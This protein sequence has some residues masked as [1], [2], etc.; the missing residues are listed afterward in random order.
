M[1][2]FREALFYYM[3][4]FD[5]FDA[6]IPRECKS[7]LMLEQVVLGRSALN[8]IACE[9]M[10]LVQRPEKYKQW[11]ARN[12]RA[13]LRQLPLKSSIVDV[14]KDEVK[15]HHHKDF[16]VCE[17][18]KWLLQ[19]WMGRVLFAHSTWGLIE[20]SPPSP[21]LF[22]DLPQKPNG[23]SEGQHH[24]PNNDMMLPY[25]SCLL[26]EDDVDDK[27]IDHPALLQ[28]QQPFAQILSTPSFSTSTVN[29]EGFNDLL[30]QG[31]SDENTLNLA[32]SKDTDAVQA[33]M[34]GMEEANMLVPKDNFRS[35]ELVNQMV[36]ESINHCGVKKRY[37][38]DHHL[39]EGIRRTRKTVMMIKGPEANL[40]NE[41]IDEM[42]LHGYET[43]IRDM[44]KLSVAMDNKVENK[45]R[46]SGSKAAR[47]DEVD[48]RALL[49]SCAEEVAT[50]NH[51][52]A[53]EL[54]K[55]IKQ[56]ASAA[57][58]ATQRMAQCFCKGL[59]ARLV[60]TQS[61]LWQSLLMAER[62]SAVEYL[63]A[64]NI[65]FAACCFEKVAVLFTNMG[66][67]PEVKITAIGRSKPIS[68]P[69]DEIDELGCRLSKCADEFGLPSFKFHAIMKEWEDV[70]TEDLNT[71]S[72]EVLIVS[73]L[74][75]FS[76]LMDESVFFDIPSPRDTVL[77]N[78]KKMRPDVFIQSI[79]NL[80]YGSS[81][82]TRF[83][84]SLFY[85][86]ALFDTLDA[87]VPRDNESRLMLEQVVLGHA[88]L[89][90]IAC[91]GMDLV[92]RPEKYRQW[93][94]RNQRA[95]LR[96]LPLKSSI[97][98]VL[99][100]EV[101]KHH[102]NDFLFCEDGNWLLQS[103]MGRVRFAH[104][105]WVAKDA[106][107]QHGR[108]CVY[109]V[110]LV[111]SELVKLFNQENHLKGLNYLEHTEFTF[112]LGRIDSPTLLHRSRRRL[113]LVKVNRDQHPPQSPPVFLDIPQE[114]DGSSESQHH[115]PNNDMCSLTSP[116]CSWRTALTLTMNS[117]AQHY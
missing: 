58:N 109:G 107:L 40:A 115:D 61:L 11:Q 16:L 41:M 15:K 95:G 71:D 49:M 27:L 28:V 96:Q 53:S 83:R 67:L 68:W 34:K 24:V 26:M 14:V 35:N 85:Y 82:L 90:S 102:H 73:D 88:A 65:Y 31:D 64:Y 48:L 79:L 70:C 99:K 56:H 20:Q 44:E 33:F 57:G 66:A 80:S 106:S 39:E 29:M 2:R 9:G 104:S 37:N 10:D 63:K 114:P 94:R 116:V 72:D 110:M 92:Q 77:N 81:F 30:Q 4:F 89:N 75:N 74:F 32:L 51:V 55:Q 12:K 84:E 13:G 91:E 117:I 78:I 105:T 1:S 86:M 22:L 45:K 38:R 43:C 36:T 100:D 52:R 111:H 46:K 62:P 7:R 50:N 3:S 60:G 93:Q 23:S 113:S 59:E 112:C 97:V 8:A 54:L 18:G 17:D 108:T 47:A 21:P 25:I 42:M 19:G 98:A 76:T 69:A 101:K 103:W 87:T 5:I 6:T